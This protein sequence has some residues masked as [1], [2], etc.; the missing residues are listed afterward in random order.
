MAEPGALGI[1]EPGIQRLRG[2][3]VRL[4]FQFTRSAGIR[5]TGQPLS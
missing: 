4:R 3:V 1:A 2:G 5:N